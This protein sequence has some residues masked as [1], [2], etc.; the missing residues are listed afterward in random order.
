ME[1]EIHIL[2][3]IQYIYFALTNLPYPNPIPSTLAHLLLP[4]Q[5]FYTL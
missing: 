2:F 1:V 5:I 4:T 3:I